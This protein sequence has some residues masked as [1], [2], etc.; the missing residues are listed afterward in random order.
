[1]LDHILLILAI[2][3]LYGTVLWYL[4]GLFQGPTKKL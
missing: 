3:G 2:L 4:M 1:M